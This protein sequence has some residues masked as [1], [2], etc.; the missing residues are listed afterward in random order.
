MN[1]PKLL[2]DLINERDRAFDD[3]LLSGT[4]QA[5]RSQ[6]TRR[7]AGNAALA[8]TALLVLAVCWLKIPSTPAPSIATVPAPRVPEFLVRTEALSGNELVVTTAGAFTVVTSRSD[9][10]LVVNTVPSPDLY[11]LI[12]DVELRMLLADHN[13]VLLRQPNRRPQ[14]LLDG[15]LFDGRLNVN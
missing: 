2:E 13:P 11:Q 4:L 5:V 6:R 3:Q 15:K 9:R 10:S 14:L 1:S 8:L 12:S 7:R